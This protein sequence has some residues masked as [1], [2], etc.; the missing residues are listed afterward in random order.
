M[1]MHPVDSSMMQ[2][3]GYDEATRTLHI[4]FNSGKT[5][6]YADVPTDVFADFLAADSKGVFFRSEI[7][8]CYDYRLL[9]K[10]RRR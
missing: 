2:A 10:G 8:E 4:L 7:D 6:E 1:N 3:I 5:Y 9:K